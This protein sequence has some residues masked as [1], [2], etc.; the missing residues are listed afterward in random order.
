MIGF[1]IVSRNPGRRGICTAHAEY[2]SEIKGTFFI[3]FLYR[4]PESNIRKDS[5]FFGVLDEVSGYGAMLAGVGDSDFAGVLRCD[6]VICGTT[7]LKNHVHSAGTL[8]NE[9]G[10]CTGTTGSPVA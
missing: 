6:D 3:P 2:D 9:G 1:F 7:S 5:K 10:T 8:S 4:Y